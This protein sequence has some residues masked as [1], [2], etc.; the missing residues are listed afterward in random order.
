MQ[1]FTL[2][3]NHTAHTEPAGSFCYDYEES[4]RPLDKEGL[5]SSFSRKYWRID[6]WKNSVTGKDKTIAI[7]DTGI[8]KSHKAFFGKTITYEDFVKANLVEKKSDDISNE[9]GTF[10]AGVAAGQPFDSEVDP[11]TQTTHTWPGGVAPNAK[12]IVCRVAKHIKDF[13]S[14]VLTEAL[15]WLDNYPQHIDVVSMSFGFSRYNKKIEDGINTLYKKGTLFVAAAGNSGN[16]TFN[17]VPYPAE[18]G[19]VISVG[20]HD[21]SGNRTGSSS[22]GNVDV[23][24]LGD[25][26]RGPATGTKYQVICCDGTSVAAPAIAGLIC[27]LQE[28]IE[29]YLHA[30]PCTSCS[31]MKRLLT[32]LM[33]EK[34]GPITKSPKELETSLQGFI[35]GPKRMKAD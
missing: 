19:N 9:H 27:I 15:E 6:S 5:E 28:Y 14:S 22:V 18:Y 2:I 20:A 34:G 26:V 35:T 29:K 32:S 23:L 4:N 31:E 3:W 21:R 8:D 16:T 33:V 25:G 24:A 17:N 30:K 12:L 1:S 10:V 7:L 13:D 11:L